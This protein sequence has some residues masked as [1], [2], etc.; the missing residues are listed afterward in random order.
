[1]NESVVTY[2]CENKDEKIAF[3]WSGV[4]WNHWKEMKEE[5]N[6]RFERDFN[7]DDGLCIVEVELNEGVL[8]LFCLIDIWVSEKSEDTDGIVSLRVVFHLFLGISFIGSLT[9]FNTQYFNSISC[10]WTFV[11][12]FCLKDIWTLLNSYSLHLIL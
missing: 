9:N 1:M 8:L 5:R 11:F 6:C 7:D 4:L 2:W 10:L 12:F 3:W